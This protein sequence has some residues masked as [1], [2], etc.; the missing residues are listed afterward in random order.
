MR[1]GVR[2]GNDALLAPHPPPRTR[3]L[4]CPSC[5]AVLTWRAG[6]T[7]SGEAQLVPSAVAMAAGGRRES[8]RSRRTPG[9]VWSVWSFSRAGA[10][11]PSKFAHR[12]RERCVVHFLPS[13]C[14]LSL[15]HNRQGCRSLMRTWRRA[16]RRQKGRA[17]RSP[18]HSATRRR[19]RPSRSQAWHWCVFCHAPRGQFLLRARLTRTPRPPPSLDA[20]S[21]PARCTP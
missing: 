3:K 11:S 7:T 5:G 8:P 9:W 13:L 6:E 21:S 14:A 10:I 17:R 4:P 12:E 16:R 19:M 20:C 2:T 1:W 15:S 18:P